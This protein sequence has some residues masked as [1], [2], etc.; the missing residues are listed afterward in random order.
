MRE[1]VYPPSHYPPAH[2]Q[3]S[4]VRAGSDATVDRSL[5]VLLLLVAFV[6]FSGAAMLRRTNKPNLGRIR[7]QTN[8]STGLQ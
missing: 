1:S 7:V 3:E 4:V 6:D 5:L 8:F 2:I